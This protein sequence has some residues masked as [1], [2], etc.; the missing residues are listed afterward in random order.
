MT[1]EGN[2]H[3]SDRERTRAEHRACSGESAAGRTEV[4][5]RR[6]PKWSDVVPLP[7]K[8]GPVDSYLICGWGNVFGRAERLITCGGLSEKSPSSVVRTEEGHHWGG[9]TVSTLRR[10]RER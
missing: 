5:C 8:S 4:Q 1:R 2:D 3:C 10:I 7:S 6:T 9:V